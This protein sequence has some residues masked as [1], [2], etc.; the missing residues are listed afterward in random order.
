MNSSVLVERE[1]QVFFVVDGAN[2]DRS[3]LDP[4]SSSMQGPLDK[5]RSGLSV[6]FVSPAAL[7]LSIPGRYG[8]ILAG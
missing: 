4:A 2:C 8:S 7:F 5:E 1:E 3:T 6:H